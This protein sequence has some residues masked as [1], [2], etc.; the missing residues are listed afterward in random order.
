MIA[1]SGGP[2]LLLGP[3]A[4]APDRQNAGL[5]TRMIRAGLAE[6]ASRGH[7]AVLLVGDAPYYERFGFQ[8]ALTRGLALPGPVERARFLGLELVPGALAEAVGM[9]VASG[10]E[11]LARDVALG[12]APVVRLPSGTPFQPRP[13]VA[14]LERFTG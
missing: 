9:V 4:V 12:A 14:H 1:G 8:Q 13:A 7:A 10:S 5:G 6:A 11:E 3:I 2:A